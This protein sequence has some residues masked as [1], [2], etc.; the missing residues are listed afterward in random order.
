MLAF[1]GRLPSRVRFTCSWTG[2]GAARLLV[3]GVVAVAVA[4]VAIG[5]HSP[6]SP[7]VADKRGL[8]SFP[9][10]AQATVSR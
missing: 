1:A 6:S 9:L 3:V 5:S 2:G 4:W 8:R 7:S 10:V